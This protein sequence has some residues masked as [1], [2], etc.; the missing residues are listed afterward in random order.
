MALEPGPDT[1]AMVRWVERRGG[2]EGKEPNA[3]V[4]AA[5]VDLSDTLREA[6][7]ERVDTAVLTSATLATRDGFEFLRGRI[8]LNGGG[9]R[10]EEAVFPSPFDFESQTLVVVPTD[11]PEPK[12]EQSAAYD[13]ATADAVEDLAEASDGGVFVLFTSYRSLRAVAMDLR[14][15]RIAGRW[16]PVVQGERP[17]TQLLGEFVQSGRGILLGVASFWEGVD[18]PGEPLRALV[19]AK[20]PFKVPS[21]PLTAARLEAV[22]REGGNS[23]RDFMLPHAALRLK[24]GFGRLIRS[25]G[26]RGVVVLLDR[27]VMEKTY[28]RY[29]LES[30][31]PAPLRVGR[32]GELREDVRRFYAMRAEEWPVEA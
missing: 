29:L 6:L 28:G 18:V 16:P 5:P 17:R 9:M 11:L 27:R 7:F 22:E 3:V 10:L 12:G 25:R 26:D 23:F 19:L 20:L 14:R 31:P 24:Q 1:Q 30:L 4:N 21:E 8:G 15:R 32:W 2:G 13:R